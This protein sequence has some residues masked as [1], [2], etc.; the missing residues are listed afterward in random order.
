MREPPALPRLIL[1][2]AT[3]AAAGCASSPPSGEAAV[4]PRAQVAQ[5]SPPMSPE[6]AAEVFDSA[7]TRIRDSYYDTTFG[8]RSWEGVRTELRPRAEAAGTERRL[9]EV[10]QEMLD[11]IGDSHFALIPREAADALDPAAL[12]EGTQE[13]GA[14]GDV[15]MEARVVEGRVLVTRVEEAGPAREAGIRPGWELRA[16]GT[17]TFD[18]ALSALEE[19]DTPL[20]RTV[21]TTQ[22]EAGLTAALRGGADSQVELTLVPPG[23]GPRVVTLSRR[24]APGELIRMGN[25]PAMVARLEHSRVDGPGGCVGVIRMGIWLAPL[26]A[27]FD[28]AVNELR[29]CQGIVVDLR[30]NVGGVGGM[31]MGASGHFIDEV[32]PLGIMKSRGAE[33][34]FVS[35]PRRV[36][37]QGN[38]VTVFAGPVAILVDGLSISTSEIFAAGMQAVGRARVFG[39]PTP[40]QALPS[41][42]IRLPNGDVLQHAIADFTTPDGTR[43]EGKGVIPDQEVP[44]T[45]ALLLAGGDPP[46]DAAV[47]WIRSST[48]RP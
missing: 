37:P 31:V 47:A 34:R 2:L 26:S 22:V 24:E 36:D 46:L 19:L 39:T 33:M 27:A 30:G 43:I 6:R 8:G 15:G 23:E 41:A 18:E 28:R 20:A 16:L 7:W 45:Q 3:V 32:V 5:A 42:L 10:I 12:A 21:G 25:L 17:R 29:E 14:P 38:P 4:A 13:G 1:V 48:P 40:G 9:R 11:G 35:N 44:L